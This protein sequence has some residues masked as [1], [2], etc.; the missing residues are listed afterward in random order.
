MAITLGNF[1]AKKTAELINATDAIVLGQCL[2]AVGWVAG[3]VPSWV[4]KKNIVELSMADVANGGIAVGAAL[5]Q[6]KPVIYVVRY[7]GFLWYNAISIVNYAAKSKEMFDVGCPLLVRAIAMEGS[8]G[9]VA[10]NSQHSLVLRMPGINVFEPMTVN[11]WELS[12]DYHN[13][14][15]D[16]PTIIFEHR[17]SY[18]IEYEFSDSLQD[19]SNLT[20]IAISAARLAMVESKQKLDAENYQCDYFHLF[21]LSPLIWPEEL[22]NSVRK[23][24]KLLILDSDYE[25]FGVAES[26]AFKFSK[27]VEC[28]TFVMGLKRKSA[29]FSRIT[30]NLTPNSDMIVSRVKEILDNTN[31]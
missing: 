18:N 20:I 14:Q 1:I 10:G 15:K 23:T 30:D 9:P 11:E 22:I 6:S 2:T 31:T 3:T 26:L 8:I 12:W 21:R 25:D 29:G 19:G 24:K 28:E 16:L 5:N 13:A 17:L 7:Q 27:L 4:N